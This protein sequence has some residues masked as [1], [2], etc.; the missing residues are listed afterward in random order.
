M[1]SSSSDGLQHPEKRDQFQQSIIKSVGEEIHRRVDEMS[2]EEEEECEDEE[3]GP[4]TGLRDHTYSNPREYRDDPDQHVKKLMFFIIA[5]M[6]LITLCSAVMFEHGRIEGYVDA[7]VVMIVAFQIATLLT[8]IVYLFTSVSMCPESYSQVFRLCTDMLALLSTAMSIF[9]MIKQELKQ[10][11]NIFPVTRAVAG[12]TF[13]IIFCCGT[14]ELVKNTRCC[15]RCDFYKRACD[16][17]FLD[18]SARARARGGEDDG[19]VDPRDVDDD[20]TELELELEDEV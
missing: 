2:G 16:N 6:L 7:P 8:F 13:F 20:S 4:S 18:F 10:K 17:W 14:I 12:V 9:M 19:S 11:E 1:D 15:T 5:T 3:S